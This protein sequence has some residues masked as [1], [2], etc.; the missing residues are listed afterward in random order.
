LPKIGQH[1]V[2]GS[3]VHSDLGFEFLIELA[4]PDRAFLRVTPDYNRHDMRLDSATGD[5][6]GRFARRPATTRNREDGRFDS[7]VIVTNR[8]RFGRDGT[9]Y[10][11]KGY[12]RGRL[13][14]GT[15]SA[16]TLAD[17]FLDERA[18]LLELRVPWDLLNVT[19]PS[20][21]TLLF[22]DRISGALGTAEA[23]DFHFGMLTYGKGS[24]HAVIGALPVLSGGKW[25]ADGFKPWRWAGWSAPTSHSRLK[26]V[27]DSLRL[28]WGEAHGGE[29][30]P[31]S[32]RVPSN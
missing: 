22:D 3:Q 24:Q 19:D 9:F 11:A 8:A 26:P 28:L 23:K 30:A 15:E 32:P 27:F 29:P 1:R 18:G 25:S 20:S 5:D 2:A 10:R 21:R 13:R 4:S 7:L 6:F 17:W 14:Y 12:D 31:L 16:S